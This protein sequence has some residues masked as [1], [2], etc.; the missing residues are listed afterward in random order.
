MWIPSTAMYENVFSSLFSPLRGLL[1]VLLTMEGLIIDLVPWVVM[2]KISEVKWGALNYQHELNLTL[3]NTVPKLLLA[4]CYSFIRPSSAYCVY[5]KD[6]TIVMPSN[7]YNVLEVF[8]Y[9]FLG[10]RAA[11]SL[12]GRAVSVF[13]CMRIKGAPAADSNKLKSQP[14][15][16]DLGITT[17]C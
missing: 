15:S 4:I 9:I 5:H 12:H 1:K 3:V 14:E 17:P 10:E 16:S 7:H 11:W 2:T 13:W 6:V 8:A